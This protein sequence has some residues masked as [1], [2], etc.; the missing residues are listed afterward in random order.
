MLFR[1]F[2]FLGFWGFGGTFDLWYIYLSA[3]IIDINLTCFS[4]SEAKANKQ[5]WS[6]QSH[7][8]TTGKKGLSVSNGIS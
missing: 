7:S 4:R 2:G 3:L 5:L 1:V 6:V 8:S